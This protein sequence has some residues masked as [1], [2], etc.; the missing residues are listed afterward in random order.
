MGAGTGEIVVELKANIDFDYKIGEECA[1]WVSYV[2]TRALKTSRLVFRVAAN[3]ELSVREG[4]ILLRSSLGDEQARSWAS[5][6][7]M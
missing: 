5:P 3:E 4:S 7:Y 6:S 1:E 2:G